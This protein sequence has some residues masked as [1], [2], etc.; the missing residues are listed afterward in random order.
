MHLEQHFKAE[1]GDLKSLGLDRAVMNHESQT[2]DTITLRN[3][4][5]RQ[6]PNLTSVALDWSCDDEAGTTVSCPRLRPRK[7]PQVGP[8]KSGAAILSGSVGTKCTAVAEA[9]MALGWPVRPKAGERMPEDG[10][11]LLVGD[12]CRAH[13]RHSVQPR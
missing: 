9:T 8:D 13:Y 1:N 2:A 3:V 4:L 5:R 12:E 11:L 7:D 10:T 6:L